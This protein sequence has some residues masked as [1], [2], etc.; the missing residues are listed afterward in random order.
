MILFSNVAAV[1]LQVSF[2]SIVKALGYM[3]TMSQALSTK[4]G[5]ATGMNLAQMNRTYLPQ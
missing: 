4:L 1:F 2:D 5:C 3:L